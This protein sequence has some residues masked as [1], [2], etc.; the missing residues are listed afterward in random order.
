MNMLL[1][2]KKFACFLVLLLSI[3]FMSNANQLKVGDLAPNFDFEV[4]GKK[5][6]LQEFS[7]DKFVILYFY[8]KDNTPGCS[9]QA[10]RF[11][12]LKPDIEKEGGFIMGISLDSKEKHESFCAKKGLEFMLF[13]DVDKKVSTMYDSVG[14]FG[15]MTKRN[16][17]LVKDGKI[18]AVWISASY[19]N[20]AQEVLDEI[21]KEKALINAVEELDKEKKDH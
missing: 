16:T 17:F 7:K 21:R 20:N 11:Q 3:S 2:S 5:I 9:I 13:S 14:L 18:T 10:A 4:N 8:P 15:L 6:N 19:T 12:Q 1:L